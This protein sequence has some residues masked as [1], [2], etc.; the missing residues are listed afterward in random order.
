MGVGC[1][2]GGAV[3][4]D[5]GVYVSKEKLIVFIIFIG[6]YLVAQFQ[7]SSSCDTDTG[8]PQRVLIQNI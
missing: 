7:T 2:K 8:V 3:R 5:M 1:G 4:M 6:F